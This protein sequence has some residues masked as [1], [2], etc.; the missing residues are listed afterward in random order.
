MKKDFIITNKLKAI[1]IVFMFFSFVFIV[2]AEPKCSVTETRDQCEARLNA[3]IKK[4]EEEIKKL[5]NDILTE[6]GKQMTI[7]SEIKKLKNDISE[8]ESAIHKKNT[9]ISNIR[10]EINEKENSL[11]DL[12]N[13]LHREKESLEKIL[14]KRYELDDA[15]L[16]EYL[17]SNKSVSDFYEDAPAFSYVQ[18]SLSDSFNYIANIK[19]DIYGE[20]LSLEYKKEQENNE[21]YSLKLEKGKIETQKKDRDQALSVSKSKKAGLAELRKLRKAEIAKIR[22]ALIQFQGNGISKSISFGEA[23]DYAKNASE[24][25]GV[26]TAF[27]MAIM[28]QESGFGNNVGGCYLKNGQTGEGVYIKSGNK[29]MRN[30]VPGHFEAFK[31][32]TAGLGRDWSTTP[33]SCAVYQNGSYYGY[34]GA[35][36]YTQFIPGTWDLVASRIRAYLGVLVANPWNA[37]DAVMATAIFM[38]DKGATSQTYTAEYKAACGYYGSCKR[39]NYGASVLSKAA[40]IQQK[41]N[42]LERD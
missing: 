22:S 15:T 35:M 28:Q 17:L 10:N 41:I 40:M 25:T 6:D 24:K 26:R 11:E 38:K 16:F 12:N 37:R 9:L 14:R 42:T 23:Y 36:G 13:K 1:T 34:G 20:K 32:I 39:Y 3:E 7:S 21:R 2:K 27:I 8:T 29:S 5:T 31:R 4:K 19:E 33:I 30:M 18:S